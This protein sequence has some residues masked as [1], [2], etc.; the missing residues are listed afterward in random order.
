MLRL[1]G[2]EGAPRRVLDDDLGLRVG[3]AQPRQQRRGVGEVGRN[4]TIFE[5]DGKILVVDCGVLFPEEHQPGVDLILPDFAPIRDRLDDVVG[6]VL[7]HGHADHI[8]GMDDLRR[9]CDLL[10]G[11]ALTVYSTTE[12]M[13]RVLAMYP[14]AMAERPIAK[15]YAL[16]AGSLNV[17]RSK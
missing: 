10:G 14:Y 8:A 13:S 6:I 9:F 3:L 2:R 12:G 17:T 7:T 11:N 15:G 4:M 1:A 5:L 16:A